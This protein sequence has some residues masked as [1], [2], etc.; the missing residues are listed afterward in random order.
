MT[1][2]CITIAGNVL[3]DRL[4]S[5]GYL[6]HTAILRTSLRLST[7][8]A[9]WQSLCAGSCQGLSISVDGGDIVHQQNCS[10]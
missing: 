9:E 1:T 5:V 6:H 3:P 10:G 8:Q 2:S 4:H 7:Q